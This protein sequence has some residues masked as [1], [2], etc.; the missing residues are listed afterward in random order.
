MLQQYE[1][2]CHAVLVC[3][4]NCL[5][6]VALQGYGGDAVSNRL[7][8]TLLRIVN[9]SLQR[10]RALFVGSRPPTHAWERLVAAG[11]GCADV[12][13]QV[14]MEQWQPACS[15]CTLSGLQLVARLVR[16]GLLPAP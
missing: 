3:S 4:C 11:E 1:M 7:R 2:P 15:L 12:Q 5:L 9:K 6:E 8:S 16:W 13:I 14:G 10:Y